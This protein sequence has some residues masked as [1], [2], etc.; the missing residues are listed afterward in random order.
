MKYKTFIPLC[1]VG[2]VSL[3]GCQNVETNAE[4]RSETLVLTSFLPPMHSQNTDVLSAF[5]EEVEAATDGRVSIDVYYGDSL[6]AAD[7]QYDMAVTVRAI[8]LLVCMG[9]PQVFFP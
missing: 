7:Y 4:E 5:I 9:T 8:L 1:A 2:M 3:L 6:G